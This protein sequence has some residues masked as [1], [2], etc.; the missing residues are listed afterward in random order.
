MCGRYVATTPPSLLAERF[1]ADEVVDEDEAGEAA[2]ARWNVAPTTKVWALATSRSSGT[3]R[4]GPFRWGLVPNWAK[5]P[6]V[7]NRMI[8]ARVEK[9]RTGAAYKRAL[10]RRRCI[11]P[12]DAFYEWRRGPSGRGRSQ[13]FLIRRRDG[14][15]MAFAGLWDLWR[16]PDDPEAHPLRSCTIITTEA[17][18]LVGRVHDRM[19]VMLS[20]ARWEGWLDP[21]NEDL[22]VVS[23]LLVPTAAEELEMFPVGPEVNDVRNDSPELAL[24]LEGHG[25]GGPG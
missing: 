22:D 24:P 4:L 19:P 16:P 9:L 3:R 21:G 5:D 2:S 17:N 15:P 12:A 18:E 11:V 7:G 10:Q 6:S 14:E 20:R 8:N 1:G 23:G 25:P 13:P